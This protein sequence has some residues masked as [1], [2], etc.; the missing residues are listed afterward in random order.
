M[1]LAAG[2]PQITT[3]PG[4]Q[5]L[6]P[7]TP[8]SQATQGGKGGAQ[9]SHDR[10]L[11]TARRGD[12]TR[13]L[14]DQDTDTRQAPGWTSSRL[15]S[16]RRIGIGAR[17]AHSEICLARE[18][19]LTALCHAAQRRTTPRHATEHKELRNLL[20]SREHTHSRMQMSGRRARREGL[21]RVP[22]NCR[23]AHCSKK[24]R[25]RRTVDE[26]RKCSNIPLDIPSVLFR[27]CTRNRILSTVII[28][29]RGAGVIYI[30]KILREIS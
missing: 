13:P 3:T 1:R 24:P 10:L 18:L 27:E 17:G 20:T 25:S 12:L 15:D 21:P 8:C 16:F 9:S 23:P 2:K 19:A 11:T 14:T 29:A 4:R 5:G 26:S 6:T 28:H 30:W 7:P 22:G